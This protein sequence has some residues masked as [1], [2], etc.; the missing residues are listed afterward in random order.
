MLLLQCGVVEK[1][2]VN[3]AWPE[4]R[5]VCYKP[6]HCFIFQV[7]LK[8]LNDLKETC[9]MIYADVIGMLLIIRLV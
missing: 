4:L 3:L 5:Y 7:F 1:L 2:L 8:S 9:E 6:W